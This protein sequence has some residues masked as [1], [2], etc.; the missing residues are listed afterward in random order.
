M[1]TDDA[2][3]EKWWE[4][5]PAL[6][7]AP[8][9]RGGDAQKAFALS[10]EPEEMARQ[11]ALVRE[12][13]FGAVEVFAAPE[14]GK[15]FGGLDV[16]NHHQ[17]D[18][19]IGSMEDFRRLVDAAHRSDLAL[20]TF[21]N[22]GYSSVDAPHFLKA[23]DDVRAGRDSRE[24]RWYFW[25]EAKDA[26]PPMAA[27][28]D[29]YFLVQPD[30]LPGYNP[31]KDELWQWSERAES[32]YWTKWPG[33]DGQGERCRLPQY[34]WAAPEWQEEAQRI[35]ATWMDTGIDGMVLDAVNWYVGCTWEISRRCITDVIARYGSRHGFCQPEGA[36]GFRDDPVAWITEG[37]WNCVQDYGLGIWWERGG[38]VVQNAIE[39]GDPRPIETALR[40]Y[41]DRA[42]AAGAT[43]YACPPRFEDAPRRRLA[44]AAL[45]LLGDLVV[46]GGD[47]GLTLEDVDSEIQWLFETRRRYPALGPRGGRRR[48]PVGAEEKHY[49]F[50]RVAAGEEPERILVV[51]NFQ[52]EAQEVFLDLSGVAARTL[53]PLKSQ[54]PIP[55]HNALT[56]ELPP[57]GVALYQVRC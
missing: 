43:L 47:Y 25:S 34:N 21:D 30:F 42:V 27:A 33:V 6:L 49:A 8:L 56:V 19:Q 5:A 44:I 55:V 50:L 52:P 39:K 32:Y 22:L 20:I 31:R 10:L 53:V 35:I 3:A 7:R 12:R 23:C 29:R 16:K 45:I 37:G 40:D 11:L 36:G 1:N 24:R 18:P 41:H 54:A 13:G 2:M 4:S 28:G 48:L 14:G 46:F 38:N 15:S 26:P 51:L 9:K 57:F 17:I